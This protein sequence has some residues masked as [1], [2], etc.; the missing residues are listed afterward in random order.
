M[1]TPDSKQVFMFLSF[2]LITAINQELRGSLG[3]SVWVDGV[4]GLV[5][6]VKPVTHSKTLTAKRE[7]NSL[8]TRLD[9][10]LHGEFICMH[11]RT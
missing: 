9:Y 1:Q 10:D 7:C 5:G 3:T 8:D 6:E 4:G 11:G 2:V